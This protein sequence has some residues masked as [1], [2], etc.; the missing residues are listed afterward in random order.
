VGDQAIEEAVGG[1]HDIVFDFMSGSDTIELDGTNHFQGVALGQ[2]SAAEFSSRVRPRSTIIPDAGMRD[3]R[4]SGQPS[5]VVEP[6]PGP[7]PQ[8]RHL[9]GGGGPAVGRRDMA[10]TNIQ[11]TPADDTLNGTP[12][13]DRIDGGAGADVGSN[14]GT[15]LTEGAGGGRDTL[16]TSLSYTL[17]AGQEIDVLRPHNCFRADKPL[18]SA[19]IK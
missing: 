6:V 18:H 10:K 3:A 9:G 16:V 15:S 5:E 13:D 12:G 14:T 2:L 11:G 8:Q 1:G 17:A 7:Y 4:A 19:G